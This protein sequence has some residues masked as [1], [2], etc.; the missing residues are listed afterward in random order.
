MAW[1]AYW[2]CASTSS[3]DTC[4]K[5]FP[6]SFDV[7]VARAT[8]SSIDHFIPC[9][10]DP[11][12]PL[13]AQEYKCF[14]H[15]RLRVKDKQSIPGWSKAGRQRN[16]GS[17]NGDDDASNVPPVSTE[18]TKQRIAEQQ[19]RQVKGQARQKMQKKK[20]VSTMSV[21]SDGEVAQE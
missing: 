5:Q 15:I 10:R 1:V 13:K 17:L 7:G 9:Y 14:D 6:A 12:N 11:P 3:V 4:E 20:R 19:Q 18:H 8:F 16:A 2:G 21:D